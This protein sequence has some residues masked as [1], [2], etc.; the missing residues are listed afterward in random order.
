M[1]YQ[2]PSFALLLAT[3]IAATVTLVA[4]RDKLWTLAATAAAIVTL[5]MVASYIALTA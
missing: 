3:L 5:G 4:P 1:A 2:L